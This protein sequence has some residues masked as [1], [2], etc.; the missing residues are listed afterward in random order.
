[1]SNEL[2]RAFKKLK[3]AQT[4]NGGFWWF[5][6]GWDGTFKGKTAENSVYVWKVTVIDVQHKRHELTGHVTLI[7]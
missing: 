5:E 3:K 1:M 6:G 2:A 7:K 4:P